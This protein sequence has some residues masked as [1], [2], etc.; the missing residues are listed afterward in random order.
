MA[1]PLFNTD[2]DEDEQADADEEAKRKGVHWGSDVENHT[3]KDN[4][5]S[6]KSV[7]FSNAHNNPAAGI[8]A[9]NM[10]QTKIGF[11]H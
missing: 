10:H 3:R 9:V 7:N 5:R 8:V 6:Q 1:R 2:E 4:I 11:D